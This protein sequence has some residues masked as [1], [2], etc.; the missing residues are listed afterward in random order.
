MKLGHFLGLMALFASVF[1]VGLMFVG[2]RW[3]EL[4]SF[5]RFFVLALA[6]LPL[7]VAMLLVPGP[8]I[9]YKRGDVPN[10]ELFKEQATRT[11]KA[12]WTVAG[13]IGGAV[14]LWL[15]TVGQETLAKI[16]LG[17]SSIPPSP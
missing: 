10:M 15:F 9:P 4:A 12:I 11:H 3:L 1:C 7:G 13:G 6:G 16:L 14:G 8:D 2:V 17:S 5:P